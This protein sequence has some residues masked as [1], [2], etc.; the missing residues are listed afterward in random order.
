MATITTSIDN[1]QETPGHRAPLVIGHQTYGSITETVCRVA[2]APQPPRAWYIAFA[3]SVLL[4]LMLG[5]LITHLLLTGVG[6]ADRHLRL[7]GRYWP[8]RYADLRDSVSLPSELAN[9]H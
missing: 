3:I 9:Q 8:R 2:E 4:V 7:L 6:L 1:T 5:G